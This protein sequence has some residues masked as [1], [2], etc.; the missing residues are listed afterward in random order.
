M[1]RNDINFDLFN[2]RLSQFFV[3]IITLIIVIEVLSPIPSP[4]DLQN[5]VQTHYLTFRF[6]TE[7]TGFSQQALPE[8]LQLI[9]S[10]KIG[11]QLKA[12]PICYSNMVF[13][14]SDN[15]AMYAVD[16]YSGTV[17]WTNK[18]SNA[19][20]S[21]AAILPDSSLIV[22]NVDGTLLCMDIGTGKTLWSFTTN[23]KII[24]S[25]N[26]IPHNKSVVIG[27]YDNNLYCVDASSGK[28]IWKYQSESYINGSPA[29]IDNK[30]VFGGCDAFLHILDAISGK[31]LAKLSVDS[32]VA[33]AVAVSNNKAFLGTY[34]G[35]L[36]GIDINSN[37]II[38]QFTPDP[39]AQPFVSSPA[40]ADNKVVIGC[41]NKNI[42]CVNASDGKKI[43]AFKTRG[44]VDSSPIICK[45]KIVVGSSDGRI[46]ILDLEKGSESWRYEIGAPITNSPFLYKERLIIASE[47][48]K[49]YCF[50]KK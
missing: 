45:D 25:P 21:P 27:C 17:L 23:G 22:G 12:S 5:N 9:W 37:N 35:K 33:G 42:Y 34:G 47:D 11:D 8:K 30:I 36:L 14:G 1:F 4:A 24:G 38:W 43:W 10:I 48:G 28:L 31:T 44:E 13:C 29:V 26:I 2:K 19:I 7:L 49:I 39:T 32:Y 50:G 18:T 46:Y 15:G 3:Q 41:R 6:N 16:L 40:V 20:E